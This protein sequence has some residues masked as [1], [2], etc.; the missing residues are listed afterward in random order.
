MED[1]PPLARLRAVRAAMNPRIG[2]REKAL[3][4]RE[5]TDVVG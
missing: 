5:S 3:F 4:F 1:D 2:G